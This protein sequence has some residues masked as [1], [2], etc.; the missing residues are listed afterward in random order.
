MTETNYTGSA[1]LVDHWT[2]ITTLPDCISGCG[3]HSRTR[4]HVGVACGSQFT[5]YTWSTPLIVRYGSADSV[6]V[7]LNYLPP[8]FPVPG[9]Y[10]DRL[11]LLKF[12]HT[13][14]VLL[15]ATSYLRFGL[16]DLYRG[17]IP[18]VCV[19]HGTRFACTAPYRCYACRYR[20]FHCY[21]A[22][23]CH[24]ATIPPCRCACTA[25]CD[26]HVITDHLVPSLTVPEDIL[27]LLVEDSHLRLRLLICCL[28]FFSRGGCPY[29]HAFHYLSQQFGLFLPAFCGLICWIFH[30]TACLFGSVGTLPFH[31]GFL[32]FLRIPVD[33]RFT[34]GPRI[35]T[36]VAP[37]PVPTWFFFLRYLFTF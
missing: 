33:L 17:F 4:F 20:S 8:T 25:F 13:A 22:H 7:R 36:T 37:L 23:W 12:D 9:L 27:G 15:D 19:L 28:L 2:N 11:H 5:A 24:A 30:T 35:R 21:A 16:C 10:I 31:P 18:R 3:I 32:R 1:G 29:A 34:I 6:T 26:F 14:Y